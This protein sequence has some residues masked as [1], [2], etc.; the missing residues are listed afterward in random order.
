[1]AAMYAVYHGPCGLLGIAERV[2]G[3]TVA[4]A[5][6][7]ETSGFV[8]EKGMIRRVPSLIYSYPNPNPN[9]NSPYPSPLLRHHQGHRSKRQECKDPCSRLR[10]TWSQ[11][12]CHRRRELRHLAGRINHQGRRHQAA[13]RSGG[14]G[15]C[16]A[17]NN[18][19]RHTR[20]HEAHIFLPHSPGL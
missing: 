16:P 6:A 14:T 1:M 12:S 4:V 13:D 7:V 19:Q 5:K 3:M 11:Y 2:H 15:I 9:P 8:V 10:P 20:V 18:Q 17:G